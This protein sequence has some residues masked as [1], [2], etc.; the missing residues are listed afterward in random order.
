MKNLKSILESYTGNKRELG[1]SDASPINE[2]QYL[3]LREELKGVSRKNAVICWVLLGMI[4]L[5]FILSLIFVIL[6][7]NDP[8]KIK[9]I[10]GITGVSI[11]GLIIYTNKVWKEKNYIDMILTLVTT[12]DRS[13]INSILLALLNKL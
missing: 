8:N 2:Q 11:M 3:A 9:V 12:L 10:F 6:N 4:G 1:A 7:E 5:L 13:M